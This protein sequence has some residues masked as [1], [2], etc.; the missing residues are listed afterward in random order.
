MHRVVSCDVARE[1]LLDS[2]MNHHTTESLAQ[3]IISLCPKKMTYRQFINE[4]VGHEWPQC[5]KDATI[6]L[7]RVGIRV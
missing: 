6:C 7:R 4:A 2:V 1:W 5:I 3:C